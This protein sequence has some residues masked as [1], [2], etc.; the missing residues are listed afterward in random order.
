MTVQL[1]PT[2]LFCGLEE[3][4]DHLFF[5]CTFSSYIWS[6]L[7]LKVGKTGSFSS[8]RQQVILWGKIALK[9]NI[10]RNLV[11]KLTFQGCKYH[12]WKEMNSQIHPQTYRSADIIL[13]SVLLD[14]WLRI[15]SIPKAKEIY[16]TILC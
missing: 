4:R 1:A 13:K 9:R 6:S 11:T 16:S 12:I 8:N 3:D 14:I 5:Y 15:Q 2:V 10:T 7:L